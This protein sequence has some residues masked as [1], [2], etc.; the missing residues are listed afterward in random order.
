MMRSLPMLAL[1]MFSASAQGWAASFVLHTIVISTAV[2]AFSD[3]TLVPEEEPFKWEVSI[4]QASVEPDSPQAAEA[5]APAREAPTPPVVAAVEPAVA[6]E[7]VMPAPVFEPV[8]EEVQP[9]ETKPP[10]APMPE[11]VVQQAV[12]EPPQEPVRPVE[13]RPVETP[14]PAPVKS[15]EPVMAKATPVAPAAPPV[16]QAPAPPAQPVAPITT[17][18]ASSTTGV[19]RPRADY[20]WL[21]QSLWKRVVE[22]KRYP[23][24]AR[25]NHWEGKVVL[26]AVIRHDGHLEDLTLE[27]SSGYEELDEAAMELVREACP[28]HMTQPLGRSQVVVQVPITYALK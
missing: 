10:V 9:I 21:A 4:V 3:V 19:D 25:L 1:P 24:R 2:V 14:A 7:P 16:A 5:S 8:R 18:K 22:L 27:D 20:G 11:P 17:A 23:H 26:R 13:P 12:L 6:A 15:P 28:L